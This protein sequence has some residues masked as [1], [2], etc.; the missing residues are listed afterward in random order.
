MSCKSK[1]W[2]H[3]VT[4]EVHTSSI[5][6]HDL[7]LWVQNSYMIVRLLV[8]TENELTVQQESKYVVSLVDSVQ[9]DYSRIFFNAYPSQ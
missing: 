1:G 9:V 7:L 6:I 4:L 3:E 8:E 2:Q 5:K